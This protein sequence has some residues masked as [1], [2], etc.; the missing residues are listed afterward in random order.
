LIIPSI[1][2]KPQSKAD[3]QSAYLITFTPE[4]RKRAFAVSLVRSY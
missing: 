3:A 4:I 1:G 2:T